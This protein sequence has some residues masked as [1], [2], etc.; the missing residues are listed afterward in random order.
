MSKAD[1]GKTLQVVWKGTC[2]LQ[3]QYL[4]A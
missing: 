3:H 2:N 4:P 1:I